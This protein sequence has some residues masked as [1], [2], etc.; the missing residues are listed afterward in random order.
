MKSENPDLYTRLISLYRS[1]EL[2]MHMPGGKRKPAGLPDPF[3]CD[4]TE[5]DGFDNLHHAD[6]ILKDEMLIAA[7]IYG[8]EETLFMTNGSTGAILAAICG[9]VRRSDK[10][11]VARNC[12]TS[13][14]HTLELQD[15]DPVFLIPE[16]ADAA[17]GIYGKV[18]P[19]DVKKALARNSGIKAVIITS[20]T[21]EGIVSDIR[22]IADICHERGA[23]LIVDEA[24]GAHFGFGGGFPQTAVQLGADLVIQSMH[25]TLPALTQAALLHI[26]GTRVDR[27][28]VRH[29]WD[30]FETTSP[31][32]VIMGSMSRCLH[33]MRQCGPDVMEE[34]GKRVRKVRERLAHLS[35]VR[36][37]E[38]T[39]CEADPGKLAFETADAPAAARWLRQEKHI[40]LEMTSL[41]YFLAMTS[42]MD[43]E[44]DLERFAQAIEQMDQLPVK[45]ETSSAAEFMTGELPKRQ[46]RIAEAVGK[47]W[48]EVPIRKAAGRCAAAEVC[49]YPPGVPTVIPGEIFG[50]RETAVIEAARL[51]GLQVVGMHEGMV[52]CLK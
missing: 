26:N 38:F 3:C 19:E 32:Y 8:A 36:L 4:I 5:I 25:K 9:S 52:R 39:G 24:H 47:P 45:T 41:R 31:S 20:P 14:Y 27:N 11:L 48:E 42:P 51:K 35:N 33:W 29:Y 6:G 10:V 2:P 23:V 13:V 1:D 30:M 49:L 7:S 15:L 40:E 12:H 18:C 44:V 28:R 22:T 16:T 17:C 21:Y 50:E 34:Y 43:T 37:L 46:F